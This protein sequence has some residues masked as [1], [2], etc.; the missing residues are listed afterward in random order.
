MQN[1]SVLY[2]QVRQ[3]G[4]F[5][6]RAAPSYHG[7]G[8]GLALKDSLGYTQ[9]FLKGQQKIFQRLSLSRASHLFQPSLFFP[10][11]EEAV[12]EF[13]EKPWCH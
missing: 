10:A 8:S 2:V 3:P 7:A 1:S 5:L 12:D 4:S 6:E 13:G 11:A 9:M